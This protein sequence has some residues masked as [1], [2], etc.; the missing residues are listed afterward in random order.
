[1]AENKDYYAVLGVSRDASDDEIK[2]AFRKLSKKYHPDINHD[3]GAEDKF[4]E[5]NEAYQV[6]S[7]KQK[8]AAFDQYGSA[9]GPQ[10]GGFGGSGFG[11]A[12]G[13]SDFGGGGFDDIFSSFF[14]GG[15]T[16]S[17]G[18]T[19][20]RAG[21]DLQYRMDLKFEEAVFGKKSTISYNRQG[22]CHVCKGTGAKDGAQ[23]QTCSKCR[24]RGFVTVQRNTPLGVMQTRETCDVCG[25]TGKEI[26]DKCENCHGTGVEQERHE[27]EVTVPAG[28]LD[29]QQ[30]RLDNAGEAGKNGAPFGDLYI[31]FRVEPSKKY[32]RDGADILMTMDVSFAQA[33]LGDEVKADT[34]HGPVKL[35]IPAGTQAGTKIR[36]RGKGAPRLQGSGTGDEI[37]TV[38]ITTPKHL[39]AKQREAL[40]QFAAASGKSVKPNES[41][42]FDKVREAFKK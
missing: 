30:M 20:P 38:K 7:D 33:A 11:G 4:K 23:P 19:Q 2:K 18:R 15:A 6:L 1:M 41:N 26:K 21:A 39:N 13:F 12:G 27:I 25:G 28:I 42:L 17:Q 9:D 34:V 32:E 5:I 8:R 29:G 3:P 10:G 16:A 31:V 24:G 36:L 37:V 35:K 40:M 14:G 22:R